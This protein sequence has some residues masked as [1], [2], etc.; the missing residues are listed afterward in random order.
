[1]SGIESLRAGDY[2]VRTLLDYY[3]VDEGTFSGSFKP[4]V[5]TITG[6]V[7]VDLPVTMSSKSKYTLEFTFNEYIDGYIVIKVPS[8]IALNPS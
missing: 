2:T 1:M 7:D 8:A 5:S 4:T 6:S 3:V